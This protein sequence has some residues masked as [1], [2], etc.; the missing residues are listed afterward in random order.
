VASLRREFIS[1][2]L[3]RRSTRGVYRRIT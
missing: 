1:F 3:M 2:K